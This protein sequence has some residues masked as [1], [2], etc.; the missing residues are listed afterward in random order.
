[1]H[2]FP[3]S[4]YGIIPDGVTHMFSVFDVDILHNIAYLS[5]VAGLVSRRKQRDINPESDEERQGCSIAAKR[6]Y[7]QVACGMCDI[8]V[9]SIYLLNDLTTTG[10][11]WRTVKG[12]VAAGG[13]PLE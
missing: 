7:A 12:N 13:F 1:M 3:V 4:I 9:C 6:A 5:N 11:L 8:T 2:R 10:I